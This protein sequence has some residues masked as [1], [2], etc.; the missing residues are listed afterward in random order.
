MLEKRL[1]NSCSDRFTVTDTFRGQ[2][3][4]PEDRTRAIVKLPGAADAH[5]STL[6][7]SR[8]SSNAASAATS[9]W[10]I[11]LHAVHR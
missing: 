1:V 8:P 10:A 2:V 5:R 3:A 11:D 9:S 4:D 7:S 6:I